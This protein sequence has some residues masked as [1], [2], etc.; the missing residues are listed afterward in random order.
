MHICL[1]IIFAG[2]LLAFARIL[3]ACTEIS[4]S[5]ATVM[6]NKNPEN[7]NVKLHAMYLSENIAIGSSKNMAMMYEIGFFVSN[8]NLYLNVF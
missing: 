3:I 6:A 7:P 4:M 8:G 5:F 2:A 1:K